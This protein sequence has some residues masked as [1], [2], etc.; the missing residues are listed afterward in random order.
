MTILK[1]YIGGQFVESSST[2]TVQLVNPVT[3]EPGALAP[4]SDHADVNAAMDAASDAFT[5]WGQTTPSQRQAALLKL[6]DALEAN[7]DALVEAQTR[8]TGQPK[9]LIASEEVLP[10]ADQLRFFAGAA[11]VLE[12]RAQAEYLPGLTSSVRREPIGVVAQVTPWNYPL[13]MAIWK[14]APALAA[15]NT[16]VLKP[17]DTTPE[18]TLLLAELTRDILPPGVLNVV[19]GDA[20]TGRAIVEHPVPGLVSITGSVRAGIEVAVSAARQL[21]R[22]HL[23]LGG[24]APVIVFA[25]ADLDAA[26][27]GIAQAGIF[28]AGQDCT[29]ACRVLVHQDVASQFTAKLGE[30]VAALKAGDPSDEETFLGPLNN[31]GHFARVVGFIE[32]LPEHAR[33]VTGGRRIGE[34]GYFLEPTVVAGL[35]QDDELVR[36]EVFGPIIGV[37]TF[38]TEE[39][40]LRKANDVDYGLSASVWTR[41]HATA[42]RMSKHLDFGA[43]W[44]NT[45]IPLAAEMPHGGFKKSGY[46]KDLSMYGFEDYTRIKHVMSSLS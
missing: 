28:N 16:V 25:D 1:N 34:T 13:M 37:Q 12:G 32:R 7:V 8:N 20:G 40:A 42:M 23:E 2:A 9:A 3:G 45:H 46:G 6:A 43:V 24:K 19:M 36:A 15:G 33:V 29:A 10:A 44:T 22:A 4:I 41:D 14:I 30:Q 35:R 26:A 17:S 38:A 5:E 11:R 31:A 39:E 18:S 21:K 27:E